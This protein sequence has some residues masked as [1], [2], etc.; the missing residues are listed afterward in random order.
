M[1]DRTSLAGRVA[2]ITGGAGGIGSATA[3]LMAGRGARVVIADINRE[4]ATALAG[5]VGDA[6]RAVFLDLED[7][8]SIRDMI[9]ETVEAFGRLDILVNNA[10]LLSPEIA[11]SDHDIA[12]MSTGLWDRT[13]SVNCRG[14]MI[15]TREALPHLLDA[16]GAIV[17]TV[18]NLALQ[19]HLVQAA[20]S[21]SKA[22]IIQMTRSVAATYGKDGVR[23]NAVAPGMTMTPALKAAFP[24]HVRKLV[25]DETLRDR[26][27]EPDDI[28][29]A[30]AFLA[31]DAAANITGHVLVS[32]GGLASHV[33]GIA[34]FRSLAD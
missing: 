28:A 19:G 25:E 22:A 32:D 2:I 33:P 29:E 11:E 3:T 34:G 30:I 12:G 20:Y 1:A 10:A 6:A 16:G 18:S 5:Q 21:A 17:N 27:G 14:T 13:F 9:G 8:Q 15:A 26:L 24:A 7:E 23:C 31:S 4:A